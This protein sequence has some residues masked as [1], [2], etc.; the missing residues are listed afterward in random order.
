MRW[1]GDRFCQEII[2][3]I[4]RRTVH[5]IRDNNCCLKIVS[6]PIEVVPQDSVAKIRDWLPEYRNSV[7]LANVLDHVDERN[8]PENLQRP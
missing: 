2:E 4:Q 7:R 6:K 1:S 5:E 3:T 8:F